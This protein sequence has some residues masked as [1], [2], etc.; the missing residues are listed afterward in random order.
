MLAT[1]STR[2]EK[3]ETLK[4]I[5]TMQPLLN[6]VAIELEQA[7]LYEESRKYT[8][9]LA[10]INVALQESENRFRSI[11]DNAAIGITLVHPDTGAWIKVNPAFCRIVGYSEEE[12][13]SRTHMEITP[14]EDL[15]AQKDRFERYRS[16]E[17]ERFE[18]EKRYIRKDGSIVWVHLTGSLVYNEAEKPT[19]SILGVKDI[20]GQKKAEAALDQAYHR[21][22]AISRIREHVLAMRHV[23][24]LF[25]GS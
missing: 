19:Y 7:R 8:N 25:V 20:T 2:Q 16:G 14:T 3:G 22:E 15:E 6:L 11:F 1:G 13:L 17:F 10:E 12:L 21:E 23:D 24:E 9:K 4:R 18:L 5:E